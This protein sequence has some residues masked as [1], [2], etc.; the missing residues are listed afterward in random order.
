MVFKKPNFHAHFLKWVY[1]PACAIDMGQQNSINSRRRKCHNT[2]S[3]IFYQFYEC[4]RFVARI[5]VIRLLG[6]FVLAEKYNH[7]KC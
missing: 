6:Q 7:N 2:H 5:M 1:W 3:G 4:R